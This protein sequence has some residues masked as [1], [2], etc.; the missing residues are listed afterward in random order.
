MTDGTLWPNDADGDVFRNLQKSGFDF[1]KEYVVDFNIDFE[2]WPPRVDLSAQIEEV[3]PEAIVVL[4]DDEGYILVKIK[5]LLTYELVVSVQKKLS[6]IAK[7]HCG[8]C[9]SWGVMH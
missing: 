2:S 7:V 1:S 9:E 5:A 3:F 8:H 6:S 4:N